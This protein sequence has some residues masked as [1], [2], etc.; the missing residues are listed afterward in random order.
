MKKYVIVFAMSVVPCLLIGQGKNES[1]QADSI[2]LENSVPKKTEEN[3]LNEML[4]ESLRS[5]IK[6][7]LDFHNKF[8]KDKEPPKIYICQDGLPDDFPFNDMQNVA[9]FTLWN[10][11]GLPDFFKK[12]L[13]KG[14]GANFV[15]MR[16]I[17]KQIII[18]VRSYG[19]SLVGKD[20]IKRVAGDSWVF[21]YEYSCEKQQW[22]LVAKT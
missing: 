7:K 22:L 12:E 16:L 10:F 20:R 9:F 4:I 2:A 8:F 17:N 3:Q 19:L 15:S 14:I 5:V 6:F 18:A 1:A 13:K 21:T 11:N